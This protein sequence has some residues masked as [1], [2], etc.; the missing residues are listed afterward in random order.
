MLAGLSGKREHIDGA[1]FL[2]SIVALES[3]T[4]RQSSYLGRLASTASHWLY[5]RAGDK[6]VNYRTLCAEQHESR[7]EPGTLPM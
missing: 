1:G 2:A 6:N 5:E 4:L 3:V 7:I